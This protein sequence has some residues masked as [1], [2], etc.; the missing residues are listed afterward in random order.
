MLLC[1][2]KAGVFDQLAVDVSCD[3]ALQASNDVLLAEALGGSS[4][5]VGTG[6]GIALHADQA[7]SVEGSVGL[8]ITA[9]VQAEALG[10]A[11]GGRDRADAAQRRERGLADQPV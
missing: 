7:D 4:G 9:P 8:P 6:S 1:W 5:D 3:V 11:A 2:V 10:L